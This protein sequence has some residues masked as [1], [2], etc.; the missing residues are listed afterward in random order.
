MSLRTLHPLD[1]RE[2]LHQAVV[3]FAEQLAVEQPA[4][5]LVEDIHWAEDDLLELLERVVREA[6]APLVVLATSRPELLDRHPGGAAAT[7]TRPR[8]GSSRC[9]PR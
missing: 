5:V 6:R 8:S 3:E 2:R 4:I 7:G 1:A 9:P